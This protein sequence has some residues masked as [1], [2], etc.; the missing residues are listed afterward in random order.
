MKSISCKKCRRT[1][2]A[3]WDDALPCRQRRA[4]E[5]H[6]SECESCRI[7]FSQQEPFLPL[8][9]SSAVCPPKDFSAHV[10]ERIAS[11]TMTSEHIPNRIPAITDRSA[12]PPRRHFPIRAMAA[13]ILFLLI[14]ASV[15][16]IYMQQT[17]G[18]LSQ[19]AQ[20]SLRQDANNSLSDASITAQPEMADSCEDDLNGS[21][22]N[23]DPAPSESYNAQDSVSEKISSDAQNQI[24]N[25]DVEQEPLSPSDT[26]PD[27]SPSYR[28][29]FI[30]FRAISNDSLPILFKNESENDNTATG[31][32]PLCLFAASQSTY[33]ERDS[34][35]LESLENIYG[36]HLA[37][38]DHFCPIFL[39]DIPEWVYCSFDDTVLYV[40]LPATC[41][42]KD[43]ESPYVLLLSLLQP[44]SELSIAYLP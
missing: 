4:I 23:A 33:D 17:S 38:V 37:R 39:S 6:L 22:Y 32:L 5:V 26:N 28:Q 34:A 1:V 40:H 18:F 30:R 27:L 42:P 36:S 14:G 15:L 43:D 8:L 44:I 2:D 25:N 11:E 7:F 35:F 24:E 19:K 21:A 20:D 41:A 31:L 13:C 3:Y 9:R 16:G 10:M 12:K 29:D